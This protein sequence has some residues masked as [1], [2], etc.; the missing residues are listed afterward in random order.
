MTT[1][2][3]S[4]DAARIRRRRTLAALGGAALAALPAR[5]A[6]AQA[7]PSKPIRLVV[8]Y[9]TGGVSDSVARLIAPRLAERLGTQ[10]IVENR[11]GAGG[12]IG[13]DAVARSPADG[14]AFAFSAVSPVTLNPHVMKLPYDPLADLVPVASVMYSPVYLL[15]TPTFTGRSFADV[16][17][18][19]RA[20]P[21]S[22]RMATSGVA[23]VGHL[24][25][26]QIRDRAK[27]DIVHVPYKGGAQVITDAV[28]GQFELLTTNPSSA[29]NPHVARGTLRL[30]AVG[31]PSRLASHPD[32]PTLAELGHPEANLTST[33]GLFAPAATPAPVVQRVADEI[34]RLLAQPELRQRL[35]DTDNVPASLGPAEFG[36]LVRR[37]FEANARIVKAADIRAE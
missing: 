35:V 16:I 10:V 1:R 33:F 22:L 19:S 6:R 21:A 3:A 5:G 13:M 15:A 9:P 31:A 23:S 14:H 2:P 12:S 37:E 11:G 36:A 32:V 26:E 4:T 24:I 25:V 17:A 7:W 29:V 27:I 28:G 34:A 8:V 18:Q 30:L 20:K